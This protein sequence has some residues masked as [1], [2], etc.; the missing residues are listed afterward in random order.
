[1]LLPALLARLPETLGA[2]TRR[3]ESRRLKPVGAIC[4]KAWSLP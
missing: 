3:E 4:G 2:C 1:M